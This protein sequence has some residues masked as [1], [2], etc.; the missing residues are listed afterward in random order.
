M[1]EGFFDA[2]RIWQAGFMNVDAFM[3]SQLYPAQQ[4]HIEAALWP[5]GKVTIMMDEDEAGA[6]CERQCIEALVPHLYVKAIRLPD[7]AAQP[8]ELTEEQIHQLLAE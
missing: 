1:V 4:S 2:L 6:N 3:G 7:G 5:G 8:D